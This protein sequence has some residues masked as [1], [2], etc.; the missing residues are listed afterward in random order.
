MAPRLRRMHSYS[1]RKRRTKAEMQRQILHDLQHKISS[2]V[3]S[4]LVLLKEGNGSQ[5]QEAQS[6]AKMLLL[7]IAPEMQH[8]ATLMG[9]R[10]AEIVQRYLSL[11][12][13]LLHSTPL[14]LDPA[15]INDCFT[16]SL[17]LEKELQV[18]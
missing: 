3:G 4:F 13:R 15:L 5:V 14:S 12:D 18:A 11:V 1:P 2:H 17:Q 10:C 6:R 7:K 8:V 16:L 9:D